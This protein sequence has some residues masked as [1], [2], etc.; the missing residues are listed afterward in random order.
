[1]MHAK[2]QAASAGHLNH[3][4]FLLTLYATLTSIHA[5]WRLR[6][7]ASVLSREVSVLTQPDQLARQ[8]AL[9]V[10]LLLAGWGASELFQGL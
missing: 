3:V 10:L 9:L 4:V 2:L 1:M 6:L 7:Q 8:V 5:F